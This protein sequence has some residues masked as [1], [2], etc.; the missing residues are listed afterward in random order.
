[1]RA[2]PDDGFS[3]LEMLV[4][5]AIVA[6]LPVLAAAS[7]RGT[8]DPPTV[9][10]RQLIANVRAEA[11]LSGR[12]HS[13]NFGAGRIEAPGRVVELDGRLTVG[14]TERAQYTLLLYADGTF[15]GGQLSINDERGTTVIPGVY[16]GG[17]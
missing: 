10:P 6:S 5:L 17:L 15:S 9:D 16:R 2:P 1:M 3:M 8:S 7:L 4:V 12:M 11:I 13:I 14:Q